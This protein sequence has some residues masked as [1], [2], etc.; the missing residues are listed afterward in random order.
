MNIQ[1]P[2]S[3]AGPPE[4]NPAEYIVLGGLAQGPVH[5]YDLF[6]S[7]SES[8]GSVWSLGMSQVYALLGRLENEGLVSHERVIQGGRPDRKTYQLT[9]AGSEIFGQWVETPVAH[10]RDIRL[11]FLAKLHFA[12][13]AGR[14]AEARLKQA[15]QR[16]CLEKAEGLGRK[17]EETANDIERQAYQLRLAMLEAVLSWLDQGL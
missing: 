1:T 6:K 7:L 4:R 12:R 15:Q 5:G 16:V 8:L 14:E 11:Q 3:P 13:L 10:V 17:A 2:N 9:A